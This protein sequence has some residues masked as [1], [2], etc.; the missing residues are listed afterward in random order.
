MAFE[1]KDE[2][3]SIQYCHYHFNHSNISTNSPKYFEF[4][5][6]LHKILFDGLKYSWHIF[7]IE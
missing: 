6:R 1:G 5:L 3:P 2:D 7:R 4:E